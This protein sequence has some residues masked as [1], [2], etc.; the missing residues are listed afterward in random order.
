MPLSPPAPQPASVGGGPPGTDW[1]VTRTTT[2]SKNKT[3]DN[4]GPPK[5]LFNIIPTSIGVSLNAR[6]F[7]IVCFDGSS[8]VPVPR[9]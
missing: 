2:K 8:G 1:A 5:F 7:E 3:T 6:G 4:P 9:L